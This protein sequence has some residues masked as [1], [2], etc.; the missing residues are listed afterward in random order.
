[1]PSTAVAKKA[2]KATRR[3]PEDRVP[4][5]L[6][7]MYRDEA[8]EEDVSL[9]LVSTKA[10]AAAG[11]AA[12][13]EKLFSVDGADYHIPVEFP[14]G[15]ALMYLDR[16]EEGRDVATGAILKHVIGSKGWAALLTAADVMSREQVRKLM[17]IVTEKIMGAME[18]VEGN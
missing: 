8:P 6:R 15:V 5:E 2:T 11:L 12:P 13:M 1:M 14:P 18:D 4:A 17:A 7:G 10:A 16:I 3:V 9:E